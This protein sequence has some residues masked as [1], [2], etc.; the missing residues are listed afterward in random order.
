MEPRK[1]R[2]DV[3]TN[4]SSGSF[5]EDFIG[6][7]WDGTNNTTRS[8][9][10]SDLIHASVSQ[11]L[12]GILD[13]EPSLSYSEEF[14]PNN[15][16]FEFSITNVPFL[17]RSKSGSKRA[18]QFIA[19][20]R[21]EEIEH[22]V[23]VVSPHL[24]ELMSD[25]Y[26]NYMCQTLFQSC[27]ARQRLTLLN[28]MKDDLISVSKNPRGTHSLQ[29]VIRLASLPEEEAVYQRA[30]QGHIVR[31]SMETNASHVIQSL[32]STLKNRH[33]II[34]EIVGHIRELALDK[35][36]L[37]VIKK[38]VNDPQVFN[39]LL[40][41]AIVLMQDPYGNYA[42]QHMIDTWQE[43]CSFQII[44]CIKGKVVQLCIQKYSS[45]VMEKCLKEERMRREIIN[46]LIAGGKIQVLLGCPYGCYVLRTAALE[47]EP[48][49][50]EGLRRAITAVIPQI[51][52]KK[53]KPRWDE[54]LSYLS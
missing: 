25:L 33:F 13:E 17:C 15:P 44:N 22:I 10:R 19:R 3:P 37:C 49:L 30:F 28:G 20:S 41:Q 39:E 46:E 18:Q 54:I 32:L 12:S 27:S 31:L 51:H 42:L 26:G 29:T 35:L 7:S 47:A 40:G 2:L 52:Q 38:C 4:N 16:D 34:R 23:E 1:T 50:R 6:R 48:E 5:P 36:G 43:E 9:S 45:N 21:P 11:C 8:S 24:G 53:L 14:D